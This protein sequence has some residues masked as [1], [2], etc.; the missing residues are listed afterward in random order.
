MKKKFNLFEIKTDQRDPRASE[1]S[2]FPNRS[3]SLQKD[4]AVAFKNPLILNSVSKMFQL[5]GAND[6]HFK[7]KKNTHI[8]AEKRPN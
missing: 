5:S 2:S 6:H 1:V 8:Q 7:G 3:E 4:S